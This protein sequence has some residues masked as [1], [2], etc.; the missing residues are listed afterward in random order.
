MLGSETPHTE[1]RPRPLT[2]ESEL[3]PSMT[4][5]CDQHHTWLRTSQDQTSAAVESY[6]ISLLHKVH[7]LKEMQQEAVEDMQ[8]FPLT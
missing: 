4:E 2:I 3:R 7:F 6:F 1:S 5:G 8:Q